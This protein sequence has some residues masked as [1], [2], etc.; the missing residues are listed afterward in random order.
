[1]DMSRELNASGRPIVYS[2]SWPAYLGGPN[3]TQESLVDYQLIGQH[4]NLWR[5]YGDIVAP[6]GK[7]TWRVIL[8]QLWI[9]MEIG[10]AVFN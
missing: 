2:C 9:G 4:C 1:M 5:N 7:P 10:E 3:W 8:S 6:K